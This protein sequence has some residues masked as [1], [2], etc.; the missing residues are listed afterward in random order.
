[1]ARHAGLSA[2]PSDSVAPLNC[3]R[4]TPPLLQGLCANA[5]LV[6][7]SAHRDYAERTDS[8]E[9][10]LGLVGN[11]VGGALTGPRGVSVHVHAHSLACSAAGLAASLGPTQSAAHATHAAQTRPA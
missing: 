1:M 7:S 2:R 6:H 4:V 11:K 5:S 10:R 8:S 9:A 3:S